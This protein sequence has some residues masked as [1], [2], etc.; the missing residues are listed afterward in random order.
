MY[1]GRTLILAALL[2]LMALLAGCGG[3]GGSSNT[4]TN[5]TT[6]SLADMNG[7]WSSHELAAGDNASSSQAYSSQTIDSNGRATYAEYFKNG[8]ASSAAYTNYSGI[9]LSSAGTYSTKNVTTNGVLSS[10]K[11]ILVSTYTASQS[12]ALTVKMKKPT[13]C[14]TADLAGNW[15]YHLVYAGDGTGNNGWQHGTAVVDSAG[16]GTLTIA[17]SSSGV[18]GSQNLTY[19]VAPDGTMTIPAIPAYHGALNTDKNIMVW[20]N[21]VDATNKI[22]SA[23]IAVKAG[24]TFT[25]S[26]LTGSWT[27]HDLYAGDGSNKWLYGD[28]TIDSSGNVSFNTTSWSDGITALATSTALAVSSTGI[29]TSPAASTLHGVISPDKNLIIITS[30]ASGQP[31]TLIVGVKR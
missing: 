4:V 10:N 20:V 18:S 19:V 13:A 24:T 2:A 17:G 23:G 3:G 12:Y 11:N 30:G 15:T 28:S 29:I 26:D 27:W 16:A 22:Y 7:S 1:S 21:T 5:Q 14:T 8:V 31:T 6:Y 25:Q 9:K